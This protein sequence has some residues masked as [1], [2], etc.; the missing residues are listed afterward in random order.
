VD[1]EGEVLW[2]YTQDSAGGKAKGAVSDAV[3]RAIKQ[4]ARELSRADAK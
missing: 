3:E 4:L 1:P 2:A